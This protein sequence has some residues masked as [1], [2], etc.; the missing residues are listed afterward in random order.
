MY[1]IWC[2][3]V[4]ALLRYR[5]KTTKMQKFPIDSY[6]NEKFIYPFFRPPG[7]A[8]PPKGRRHIRNQSTPACKI[9][10]EST[11][12]LSRNRWQQELSYRQQIARQ[13]RTQYAEG[14]YRLKY[15]T[16]TLKS[17]LR[18]TQGHWKRNHCIDHT[19]LSISRVI[20]RWILLW[21]W[22]VGLRSLKVIES[23]PIWKL[24]YGF[25][26]AFYSNYGR[27]LSHFGDIQC[28]RMAWPW[29]PG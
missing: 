17:R 13:L 16:V 5:S 9:W 21:P 18:V 6:S 8:N 26:F 29:K 4:H 20:W 10:L 14:I 19:R 15:Y 24:G 11:R 3:S 25:L 27:M 2:G 23:G 1:T 22:N 7:A 12:G 28:Q